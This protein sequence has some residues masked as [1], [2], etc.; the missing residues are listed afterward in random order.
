MPDSALPPNLRGKKH[1]DW[2]WPLSRIPRG[3]TAFRWGKPRRILGPE[4]YLEYRAGFAPKPIDEAGGWQFSYYP[5]APWWAKVTGLAFYVAVSGKK[6]PD[7][8]FRHWRA[9]TRWDDVD[10]Y[11]TVLSV[12]TRRF[13]GNDEQD[14][15]T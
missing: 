15:S 10:N 6:G 8:K 1:S 14:T 13:T 11:A 12:A 9:G 4:S 7:G 3:A 2:P 5:G